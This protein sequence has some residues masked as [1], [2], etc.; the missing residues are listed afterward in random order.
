MYVRPE[1]TTACAG[2]GR[3]IARTA[4][5]VGKTLHVRIIRS[6]PAFRSD[7]IDVLGRVLDVA[8]LTVDA[9]LS[10]DLKPALSVRIFDK[11]VDASGT[12]TL[13][14]AVVERQIDLNRYGRVL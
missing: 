1:D 4:A 6:S 13:F 5:V 12:I 3:S 10:I 8:G 11:L 14:R 2:A 9:V 7:P